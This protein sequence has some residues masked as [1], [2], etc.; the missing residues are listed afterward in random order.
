VVYRIDNLSLN[1]IKLKHS[2]AIQ[3]FQPMY[4]STMLILHQK[5]ILVTARLNTRQLG[6]KFIIIA[7]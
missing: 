7:K 3:I 1:T 5:I 2:Y 4:R 6:N